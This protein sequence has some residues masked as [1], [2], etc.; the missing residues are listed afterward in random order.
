[1]K[2][3]LMRCM[4]MM[5]CLCLFL[6]ISMT[7]AASVIIVSDGTGDGV[8][9]AEGD[10][11][12]GGTTTAP[13]PE[14]DAKYVITI[15]SPNGWYTKSATVTVKLEDV[16]GTG[17]EKAEAKI[18]TSGSW[19]DISDSFRSYGWA[20]IGISDNATIYV[21]VTDKKGKTH[22]KSLYI[23]CFDRESPTVRAKIEGRM[24]R[25]EATDSLSGVDYVYVNG[26]QFGDVINGTL[27]I[28]VKD[29]AEDDEEDIFVQAVDQAGNKSKTVQVDNPYYAP[30]SSSKPETSQAPASTAPVAS[31]APIAQAP[32]ESAPTA[33][34]SQP[35]SSVPK[36]TAE[37][38]AQTQAAS[39]TP[40]KAE[41]PAELESDDNSS[42]TPTDGS[43]TVIENSL[44]NPDERE[45]FT[46]TTEAGNDYYIVVD[47][48]KPDKN[49]YLLSE[50]TEDDLMG[51]AKPS[52]TEHAIP[53]TVPETQPVIPVPEQEADP[54]DAEQESVSAPQQ[55][56]DKSTHLVIAVVALIAGVAG[57]YF[58]IYKPKQD[59][60]TDDDDG[61]DWDDESADEDSTDEAD[62]YDDGDSEDEYGD[63]TES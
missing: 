38:T 49:V 56:N 2:K 29:Y 45:F 63:E 60:Y 11:G 23:E 33:A 17:F 14:K 34:A 6:S 46:I 19:Q 20:H 30:P 3:R 15:A 37:P 5:L 58:K 57:W 28:R 43:G 54:A 22:V 53:D 48:E 24:L 7:A 52:T 32:A 27:D 12:S 50:V 40:V 10:S 16:N 47:K 35:V 44:K 61:E 51:L 55:S 26:Y 39:S 62:E 1:M 31:S 18:G 9:Q 41:S 25:V 42:V 13:E 8:T 4:A 36:Q 59:A 21:T